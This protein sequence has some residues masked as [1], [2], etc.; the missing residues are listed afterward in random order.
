M[1]FQAIVGSLVS[2]AVAALAVPVENVTERVVFSGDQLKSMVNVFRNHGNPDILAPD[3]SISCTVSY[4]L[5]LS[6]HPF[7]LV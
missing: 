2:L 1:K 6:T 5:A 7:D 3:Q 4:T